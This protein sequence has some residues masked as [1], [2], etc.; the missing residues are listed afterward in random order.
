MLQFLP[1]TQQLALDR[2]RFGLTRDRNGWA[3]E[4]PEIDRR[5]LLNF[6]TIQALARKGLLEVSACGRRASLRQSGAPA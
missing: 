6:R 1:P 3:T 2:A 4:H 5:D